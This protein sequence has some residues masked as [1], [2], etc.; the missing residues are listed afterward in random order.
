MQKLKSTQEYLNQRQEQT[1]VLVVF[2]HK[3]RAFHGPYLLG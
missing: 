3:Q 1:A 2:G